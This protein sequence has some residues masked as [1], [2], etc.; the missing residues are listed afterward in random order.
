MRKIDYLL[1]R[2]PFEALIWPR[3]CLVSNP[4]RCGDQAAASLLHATHLYQRGLNLSNGVNI[5]WLA[6]YC[7]TSVATIERHYG[8]YIKSD[9]AEQLERLAGTVTPTGIPD[10]IKRVAVGQGD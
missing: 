1:D 8:K 4:K 5:K 6:E 3:Q 9:A 2:D 7:G 10:N